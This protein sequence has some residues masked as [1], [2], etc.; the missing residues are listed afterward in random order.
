MEFRNPEEEEKIKA[1]R[2]KRL[3]ED[4]RGT[5]KA[6]LKLYGYEDIEEPDTFFVFRNED[7]NLTI[8][9]Y[10][11][12]GPHAWSY[13]LEFF[14]G[15]E[16][17]HTEDPVKKVDVGNRIIDTEGMILQMRIRRGFNQRTDKLLDPES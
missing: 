15:E 14:D 1:E 4:Y 12:R 13:R 7:K 5:M 2:R 16:K 6:Y 8:R 9:V 3:A 11:Y 17:V 10:K